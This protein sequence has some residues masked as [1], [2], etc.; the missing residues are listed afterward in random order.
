MWGR[1]KL[2]PGLLSEGE[3]IDVI[4]KNLRSLAFAGDIRAEYSRRKRLRKPAHVSLEE[5]VHMA[6]GMIPNRCDDDPMQHYLTRYKRRSRGH[7]RGLPGLF[8]A[9][10]VGQTAGGTAELEE[11]GPAVAEPPDTDGASSDDSDGEDSGPPPEEQEVAYDEFPVFFSANFG[12]VEAYQ[13]KFGR[14][15]LDRWASNEQN[16]KR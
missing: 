14:R 3:A 13:Q 11:G 8:L 6:I 2:C 16:A 9:E 4:I 5:F 1:Y 12:A 15:G 7:Q 10:G